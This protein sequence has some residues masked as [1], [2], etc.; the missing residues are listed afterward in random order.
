VG[1]RDTPSG[2][3]AVCADSRHHVP[4]D[5]SRPLRRSEDSPFRC[6]GIA[7]TEGAWR[8]RPG[9]DESFVCSCAL[10]NAIRGLLGEFGIVVP[11]G[12]R[13]LSELRQRAA[14]TAADSLPD[15][16]RSAVTLLFRQLE[17]LVAALRHR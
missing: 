6:P 3:S 16:A 1:G 8:A 15:E 13:R 7:G 12:I 9:P 17:D 11:K 14:G 5:G 4:L 2:W 10:A